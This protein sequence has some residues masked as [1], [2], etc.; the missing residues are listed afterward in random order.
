MESRPTG[1][2]VVPIF[3]ARGFS[4][5]QLKVN[6]PSCLWGH[7][8]YPFITAGLGPLTII[9][10]WRLRSGTGHAWGN[11]FPSL[12]RGNNTLLLTYR[13]MELTPLRGYRG[14]SCRADG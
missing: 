8:S 4:V 14:F 12:C 1:L 10:Q 3:C 5:A 6:Q 2:F 7:C 9:D 11:L 13:P